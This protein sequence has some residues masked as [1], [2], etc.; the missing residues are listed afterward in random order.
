MRE[1]PKQGLS[2]A[3]L[4]WAI[5]LALGIGAGALTARLLIPERDGGV[6]AE[7]RSLRDRLFGD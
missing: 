3:L 6:P 7:G 1:D 4:V 2:S 5:G